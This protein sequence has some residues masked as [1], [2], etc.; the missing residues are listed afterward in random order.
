MGSTKHIAFWVVLFLLILAL[1]NLFSGDKTSLSSRTIPF[2]D[3]ISLVEKG[4][5]SRVTLDGEKIIINTATEQYVTV[6]PQGVDVTPVLLE[7]NVAV[8]ARPQEK[9]R[10]I[11][12]YRHTFTFSLYN[13]NLAFLYE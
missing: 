13:W 10:S 11:I 9:K 6:K 4:E 3:F 8:D 7:N 1:F 2:S 12:I 5:A